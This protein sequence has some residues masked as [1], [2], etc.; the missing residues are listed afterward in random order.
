MRPKARGLAQ[1]GS[2]PLVAKW[3]W[4]SRCVFVCDRTGRT[5]CLFHTLPVALTGAAQL[6]A[7]GTFQLLLYSSK[8]TKPS[9]MSYITQGRHDLVLYSRPMPSFW[10]KSVSSSVSLQCARGAKF[11]FLTPKLT[12][13]C[14]LFL[15]LHPVDWGK[16][17]WANRHSRDVV[18]SS[19]FPPKKG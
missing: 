4:P 9:V 15:I 5:A 16:E 18:T 17:M 13:P 14:G 7:D 11:F 2:P 1:Q 10:F 12:V 19:L 6:R 8:C 3:E